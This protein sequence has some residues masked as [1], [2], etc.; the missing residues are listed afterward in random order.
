[1]ITLMSIL[2]FRTHFYFKAVPL[3]CLN[4]NAADD[5]AAGDRARNESDQDKQRIRTDGQMS[6]GR[7]VDYFLFL[8]HHR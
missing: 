8:S 6:Y 3:F 7:R 2:L 1:M 5:K 4:N